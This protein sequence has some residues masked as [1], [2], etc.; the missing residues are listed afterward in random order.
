MSDPDLALVLSGGGARAAYQVGVLRH[1]ASRYPELAPG[2]L[3]GVSA[4]GIIA[5]CLASRA[6]RFGDSVDQLSELWRGLHIEDV[7]RV[8]AADLASRA[9]RWGLRLVSGGAP[10]TPRARSLV[11]TAPLHDLLTSTLQPDSEG[12]IRAIERNLA[13][14]RLHAVALTASSYTTGQSVTWVQSVD[15]CGVMTWERQ[16]RKSVDGCLRVDHVM[17]SSALPF[18]FPA[19]KIDRAWYGD[20]GIRLT[21]PLSP[22]IHLGARKIDAFMRRDVE[23]SVRSTTLEQLARH[24][25]LIRRRLAIC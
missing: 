2:I 5:T 14:S 19:V 11:D 1:L 22:A 7:F 15:G 6:G 25:G 3:T 10:G 24:F 4:G 9:T 23:R 20:G 8:D 16:Q 13:A 18:F 17:A 21:A 12:R